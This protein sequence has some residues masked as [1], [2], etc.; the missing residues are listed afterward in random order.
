MVF[1]GEVYLSVLHIKGKFYQSCQPVLVNA[2]PNI[3]WIFS[4]N[5]R[6]TLKMKMKNNENLE[7]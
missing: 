7:H 4:P 6:L 2:E 1:R 5:V 3:Y